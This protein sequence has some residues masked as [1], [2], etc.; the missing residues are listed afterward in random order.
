MTGAEARVPWD[1]RCL[2]GHKNT[3]DP[4]TGFHLHPIIWACTF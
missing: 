3:L 4:W 2:A 1:T